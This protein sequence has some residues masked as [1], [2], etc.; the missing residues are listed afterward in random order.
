MEGVRVTWGMVAVCKV[1]GAYTKR[2]HEKVLEVVMRWIIGLNKFA[3]K[4]M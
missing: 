1:G 3:A 2:I 4:M